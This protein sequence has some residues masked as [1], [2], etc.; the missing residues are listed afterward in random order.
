MVDHRPL[1]AYSTS[2]IDPMQMATFAPPASA[3]QG[4]AVGDVQAYI[5]RLIWPK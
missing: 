1:S 5:L 3:F 4:H 2:S